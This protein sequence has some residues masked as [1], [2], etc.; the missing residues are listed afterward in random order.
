MGKRHQALQIV[1]RQ[2]R[3]H[4]GQQGTNAAGFGLEALKAQQWVEPDEMFA[5]P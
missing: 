5:S 1:H 2:V 3:A 4:M